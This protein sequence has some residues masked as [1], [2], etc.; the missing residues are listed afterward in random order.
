MRT[1]F[2]LSLSN[3]ERSNAGN[4][5]VRFTAPKLIRAEVDGAV[6]VNRARAAIHSQQFD[7]EGI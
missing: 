2:V 5:R 4:R 1:P 3:H 7:V 6:N